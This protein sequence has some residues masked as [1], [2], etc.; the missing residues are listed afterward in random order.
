LD[1]IQKKEDLKRNKRWRMVLD[2]RALNDKT[3][4]NAYPLPN[5]VDI[6][7]QLGGARYFS[8]SLRISLNKN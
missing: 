5:I 3:I 2:F 8:V 1:S 6:L 4:D 7:D